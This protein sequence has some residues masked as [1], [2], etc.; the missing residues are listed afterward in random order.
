MK[1]DIP[2][3]IAGYDR[4]QSLKRILDS[5]GSAFYD[6]EVLLYISI[7]GGGDEAVKKEAEKFQWSHGKKELVFHDSNLGLKKH[8][9]GC[10][11][12]VR[13]HDGLILLED[14]LVVSD[15]FYHFSQLAFSRYAENEQVE[16]VSLYSHPYN[17]T[18]QF[19]FIPREDGS[20][21]FFFQYAPSWGQLWIRDRWK[22][23]M[24]WYA[25]NPG[26]RIGDGVMMP[27]NILWWPE[28][29]WKKYY[30]QYILEKDKYFVYPR[31]SLTTLFGDKG[32]HFRA[33]ETF[34]QAPL[35]HH[36]KDFIFSDLSGSGAVYD[37]FGEMEPACL[38]SLAP[39][40]EGFDFEVDLYGMKPLEEV[41]REF[42][43]TGRAAKEALMRF[44]RE[45][46]P[47][48]ENII[49]NVG[50]DYFALAPKSAVTD[51]PYL[52]SLLKVH[53]QQELSY[54]YPMREYHFHHRKLLTNNSGKRFN[55]N[56][57]AKKILST[58]RYAWKYF[59]RR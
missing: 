41:N 6:Q 37:V 20:D 34:L 35:W 3:V 15:N 23:F 21:V 32:T 22:D 47:H 50:G 45:M 18:S 4:P 12:L 59:F 29:S 11:E 58:S 33:R 24:K 5:V 39:H 43:L 54:W 25:D 52:T 30:I 7:D 48:E 55:L 53:D 28:G 38:R 14:D 46:K 2:I 1:A 27:Q 26:R 44:G 16:G 19:P 49:R 10:G 13:E 31:R 42:I 40:L 9:L 8:I 36:R 56:F 17:E 57:L 51:T